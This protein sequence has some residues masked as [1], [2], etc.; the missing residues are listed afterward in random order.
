MNISVIGTGYV[1]LVTGTCLAE[2]GMNVVCVDNNEE[3][4]NNLKSFIIPIYEPGLESIITRNYIKDS[5]HFTINI[6]EA[7]EEADII[8]ISVGTPGLQDGK[9]DL[10]YIVKVAKEIA[11]LINGYKLIIIKSTVPVGTCQHVK[12]IINEILKKQKKDITFDIVSNPEFLREGSAIKDFFTPDRIVIGT[13][14]KKAENLMKSIYEDHIFQNTP[15]VFT[16][17]ETSEMIKYASNAFL[18][19][20]ISFINEIANICELCGADISVVAKAMG[21]D[22]RIGDK[23]LNPGPGFGGSCFPKDISALIKVGQDLG[24]KPK[25]I[26]RVMKSNLEQKKRSVKMIT[27]VVGEVQN[28]T[29]TVLGLA[30]K[31]ETD[32]IRE[33]SSIYIVNTLLKENA[34]VK[35]F[36]PKAMNN[37]K[38]LYPELAVEYCDD[39]YSACYGSDCIVLATE[40][41]QFKR[42]DFTNIINNVNTPILIDLKNLYEP[43]LIKEIGFQYK[44]IGRQ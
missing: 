25:I 26:E 6:K 7:V 28:K 27:N 13:E 24:Y 36:D 34:K 14:N 42:L 4:I 39:E 41:E 37:M 38:K 3:K 2:L 11:N 9:T 40:W 16:N 18:A 10:K 33:S 21:L 1:G 31:A 22:K 15:F 29:I 17:L 5:L 35:V 43:L 30:F 20:K 12:N 32:D 23:F 19:T 8:F 44:G